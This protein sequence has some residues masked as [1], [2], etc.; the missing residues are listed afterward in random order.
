MCL[1]I[2][3]QICWLVLCLYYVCE[4]C[5]VAIAIDHSTIRQENVLNIRDNGQDLVRA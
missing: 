3:V 1:V 2:L 5:A 4:M